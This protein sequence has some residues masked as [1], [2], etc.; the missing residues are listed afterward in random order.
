MK[1]RKKPVVIDAVRWEGITVRDMEEFSRETGFPKFSVTYRDGRHGCVIPT[2]EGHHFA[3]RGDWIIR[4]VNG[5]Y[6]PCKPDIFAKTYESA[7]QGERPEFLVPAPSHQS[8]TISSP[9]QQ[10]ERDQVRD[11]KADSLEQALE[12]IIKHIKITA[13]DV[14]EQS[15]VVIMARLALA[16]YRGAYVDSIEVQTERDTEEIS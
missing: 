3:E 9:E 10:K 1:Y 14:A 8:P 16:S 13:G 15:T 5:E 6:Y 12:N 4:G 2:L 7:D 11:T